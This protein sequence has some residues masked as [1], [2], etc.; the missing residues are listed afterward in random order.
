MGNT[1]AIESTKTQQLGLLILRV[2]VGILFFIFGWEKVTGGEQL[3]AGVGGSMKLFGIS[4]WPAFWGLLATTAEFLGG[5][6][7]IFGLFTR[8]AAASLVF[9]MFVAVIFKFSLGATLADTTGAIAMFLI[10]V[11]FLLNGGGLYSADNFLRL[12]RHSGGVIA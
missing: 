8:F 11:F 6:L 9:T 2:G 5:L 12:K 4:A 3:W 10:N 7:L 1:N